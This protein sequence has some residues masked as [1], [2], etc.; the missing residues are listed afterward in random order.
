M[1]L[2]N[3]IRKLMIDCDVTI[4]QL[5]NEISK[6]KNKHYT[7]Q[8]LSQKLKNNTLNANEIGIILDVLDYKVL[9]YPKKG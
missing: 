6:A 9:F 2:C 7:V 4:T 5:A 3:E 8:N 1:S